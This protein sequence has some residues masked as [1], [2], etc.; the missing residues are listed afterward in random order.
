K[1]IQDAEE[2]V[3]KNIKEA[4]QKG[5]KE[6]KRATEKMEK[7]LE[8]KIK[9]I[10]NNTKLKIQEAKEIILSEIDNL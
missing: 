6:G 7:Q 10:D 3:E 9:I 5:E 1:I 4:I 8:D 2:S